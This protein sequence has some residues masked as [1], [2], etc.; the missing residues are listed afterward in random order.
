LV[1][2]HGNEVSSLFRG[3]PIADPDAM[4]FHPFTRRIPAARSGLKGKVTGE[5]VRV[6][7]GGVSERFPTLTTD[8]RKMVFV[9]DCAGTNDVWM[10]DLA[11]GEE[12]VLIGTPENESRGVISPDVRR[13]PSSASRMA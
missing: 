6:G 5:L 9:S 4:F 12:T 3:Q 8:G 1:V 13:W 7:R 11:T 2:E 10:K